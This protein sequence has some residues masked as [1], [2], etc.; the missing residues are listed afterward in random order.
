MKKR[1]HQIVCML[2]MS[3]G[4]MSY[5]N[6]TYSLDNH[7]ESTVLTLNNVKK[8]HQLVIKD[9]NLLILYKE[10]IQ[11]SGTYSKGF[12][13]TALPN[14]SYYFELDKDV[15]IVIIPFKVVESQ[16]TFEKEKE[17]VIYKPTVRL[18]DNHLFI[19][20]LSLKAKPL[21]IKLYY[22]AISQGEDLIFSEEI[23]NTKIVERVYELSRKKKGTYTIV[24]ESEGREFV[25]R[26]RL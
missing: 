21:T 13:L 9:A 11:Q 6:S 8:G 1:M 2:M 18:D 17:T 10:A 19:S 23:E 26:I 24:F 4:I 20:R 22:R 7:K 5:A 16:V 12:D 15:E 3:M 25:E 14:G